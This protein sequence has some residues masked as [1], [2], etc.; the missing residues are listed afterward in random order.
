MTLNVEFHI[1]PPWNDTVPLVP[2]PEY[3]RSTLGYVQK[4]YVQ[5]NFKTFIIHVLICKS[6]SCVSS[7]RH[8]YKN[9]R[10]N[11]TC[12]IYTT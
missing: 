4:I 6:Y 9:D 11:G 1:P 3:R 2:L 10:S 5:R 8:M 7:Q 12:C